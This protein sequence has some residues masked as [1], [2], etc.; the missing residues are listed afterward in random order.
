M[1]RRAPEIP[2]LKKASSFLSEY[3][4]VLMN[5]RIQRPESWKSQEVP[6]T[7]SAGARGENTR[8]QVLPSACICVRRLGK[9]RK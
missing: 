8:R 3:C 4:G 9:W 5:Q 6:A 2:G 7:W 1:R